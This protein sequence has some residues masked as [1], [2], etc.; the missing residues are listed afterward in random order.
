MFAHDGF[1]MSGG[2]ENINQ[3]LLI[4]LLF[5]GRF[6]PFRPARLPSVP[7]APARLSTPSRRHANPIPRGKMLS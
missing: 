5:L 6:E 3:R 4:D 7:D 1:M 2:M